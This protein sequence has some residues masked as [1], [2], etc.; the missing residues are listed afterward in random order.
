MK[1]TYTHTNIISD[2]WKKLANFYI[3]VFECEPVPPERNMSGQWLD[4]GTGVSG[5]RIRGIHLRL[6]GHGP[7][8]PTLEIFSYDDM[9]PKP[10]PA[11]NRKGF[12]HIAFKVEDMQAVLNKMI[13]H[14]GRAIG[15]VAS[16]HVEGVGILSFVY[17]ADPE[18]NIIEIQ[19]QEKEKNA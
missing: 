10:E 9:L 4:R 1:S 7:G 12:S 3:E 18:G 19:K 13:S 17:A 6:P 5:A 16:R 8:G 14:G 2:D 15:E 11:A